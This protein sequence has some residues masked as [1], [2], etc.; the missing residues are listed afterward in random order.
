MT[1]DILKAY[2]LFLGNLYK[3]YLF[4]SNEC[5][6]Y[7][8]YLDYVLLRERRYDTE[9]ERERDVVEFGSGNQNDSTMRG[10]CSKEVVGPFRVGV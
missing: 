8:N 4:G 10:R 9:R 7:F 6:M 3:C 2:N 5:K 1:R